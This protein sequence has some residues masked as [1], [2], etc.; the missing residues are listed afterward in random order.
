MDSQLIPKL[1]W[2]IHQSRIRC[3]VQ[4]NFARFDVVFPNFLHTPL[5]MNYQ[6][7]QHSRAKKTNIQQKPT[8]VNHNFY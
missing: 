4:S 3:E 8:T 6:I 7:Y 5:S 1:E 2:G